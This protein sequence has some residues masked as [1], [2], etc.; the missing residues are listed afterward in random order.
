MDLYEGIWEGDPSI[1]S[2]RVGEELALTYVGPGVGA[3]GRHFVH[4]GVGFTVAW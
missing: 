3:T 4:M 1:S 2:V